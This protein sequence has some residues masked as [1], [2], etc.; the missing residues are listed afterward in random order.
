M[1][2]KILRRNLK[3]FDWLSQSVKSTDIKV[4][5]IQSHLWQ[6]SQIRH[7][8]WKNGDNHTWAS[9]NEF[10]HYATIRDHWSLATIRKRKTQKVWNLKKSLNL[11]KM[12][13]SDLNETVRGR[14]YGLGKLWFQFSW[15]GKS[16]SKVE[17]KLS[18][19]LY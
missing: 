1:Y 5:I 2:P 14:Q 16:V 12:I 4:T 7:L 11:P 9:N 17:F 10:S 18:L 15:T 3:R 13:E 19:R 8:S 6:K